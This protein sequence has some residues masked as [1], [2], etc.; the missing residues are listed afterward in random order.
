VKLYRFPGNTSRR[1][2]FQKSI[3]QRKPIRAD[4]KSEMNLKGI[5]W[6]WHYWIHAY[7]AF[8]ANLQA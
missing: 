4:S 7:Y 2:F 3:L 6:P 1:W 8:S 5:E